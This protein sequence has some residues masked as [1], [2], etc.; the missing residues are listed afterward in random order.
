[1]DSFSGTLAEPSLGV[2]VGVLCSFA[3]LSRLGFGILGPMVRRYPQSGVLVS[4]SLQL[5]AIAVERLGSQ[6]HFQLSM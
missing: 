2:L 6:N 4:K 5:L 3:G 1:L